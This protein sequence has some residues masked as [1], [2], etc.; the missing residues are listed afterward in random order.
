M[1]YPNIEKS[2]FKRGEYVGYCDGAWRIK[3]DSGSGL[4]WAYPPQNSAHELFRAD[5]LGQVSATL[6]DLCTRRLNPLSRVKVG[7][8]SM[9]TGKAPT[10]R[11]RKRRAKTESLPAG[12]Y[13]N[14]LSRVKVGSP[15]QRPS[16]L[17]VSEHGDPS[18]RLKKRRAKTAQLKRPG[19]YANPRH[20]QGPK[21]DYKIARAGRDND[22]ET[23]TYPYRVQEQKQGAEWV[24]VAGFE[25]K[26]DAHEYAQ[27][28]HAVTP[29]MRI[30]VQT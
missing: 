29:H 24:T 11:L 7:S 13:A 19:A 23:L 15:S 10:K 18:P 22:P 1:N 8:P 3:K 27:A 26:K 16:L 4:W 6:E 17:V 14:P 21:G 30:R 28:R 9:L 5:T 20:W 12:Y 25:R 2:A